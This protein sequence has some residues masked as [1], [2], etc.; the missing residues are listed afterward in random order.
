MRESAPINRAR[1]PTRARKLAWL[2]IVGLSLAALTAFGYMASV[3]DHFPGEVDVSTWVQSWRTDWLDAVMKAV[4]A[5]GDELVAVAIVLLVTLALLI[6]GLR[7]EAG[8]IIGATVS[9][10]A[11]R[12]AVKLAV[13]RPRPTSALVEVVE[14]TDGYSFPSGHVIHYVVLLG[15]LAFILSRVMK[16]GTARWP[17]FVATAFALMIVGLSRIYLG[18]HWL[19]DVIAGYAFGA[20][21]V[22]SS[23]RTWQRWSGGREHNTMPDTSE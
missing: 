14:Q 16:P 23:V 18:V 4:S 11:V 1:D 5:A 3:V 6:R 22:A 10:Y 9:G 7:W 19:G 21:V 17:I 2:F 12:T 8:L 13:A 20:V 15:T